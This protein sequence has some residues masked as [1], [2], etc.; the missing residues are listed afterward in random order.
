MSGGW[1]P[2][3]KLTGRLAE[4]AKM[5]N[6]VLLGDI[7]KHM[8]READKPSTRRQDIIHPSEMA[9]TGWCP[10]GTYLRIKAC[11]EAQ[12]PFLR[13]KENIGVQLLNIFDEG[14]Y[15]H[16]KWQ[17]RLWEMGELWGNFYCH[18]CD[19]VFDNTIAMDCCWDCGMPAKYMEYQE[20]PLR[21]METFL[22]AGHAD[23]GVPS[24]K[25]L[26]EIKSVGAGTVRVSNP[27]LY[28]KFSE[29][30][31]VDLPGLWKAIE[32]P[33]PDHVN[34]GQLYLAICQ[35]MGLKFDKVVFLYESKFNQGAKE[36]VIDYDPKHTDRLF[37]NARH[38]KRA[39]EGLTD[40][41]A[42]PHNG[43]DDCEG[44][45]YGTTLPERLG[46]GR[47]AGSEGSANAGTT[48]RLRG[49]GTTRRLGRG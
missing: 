40:P 8:M 16:D 25:A 30:Q 46:T 2:G 39:L 26:I 19:K 22:I 21:A 7:Q 35:L 29:G 1:G 42:C 47:D 33:F 4:Y 28:K 23:G 44:K 3:P 43:C 9:K 36:F 10:L 20:I 13:P 11:R 24:K 27:D 41:P 48:R 49:T 15:I 18:N 5:K 32:E 31:K 14:H 12:N 45:D 38:I 6:T 37:E 34:Q 17:R